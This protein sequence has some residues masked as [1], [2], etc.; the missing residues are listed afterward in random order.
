VRGEKRTDYMQGYV[1]LGRVLVVVYTG[2][3]AGI[4]HRPSLICL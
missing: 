2:L 3:A 1:H 4:V